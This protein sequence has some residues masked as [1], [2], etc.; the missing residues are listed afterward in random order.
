M[1]R[2]I[3]FLFSIA[4][5]ASAYSAS[6]TTE[7]IDELFAV[8]KTEKTLDAAYGNMDKFMRQMLNDSLRGEKLTPGQQKYIDDFSAKYVQGIREELSWSKLHPLFVQIYQDT[9]SQEEI[10]GLVA[11]YKSPAG[12]A[13]VEKM[14]L[15]M[16]KSMVAMQG[17]LVPLME[18]MK[19]AARQA[20]A[21]AK[22]AK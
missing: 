15:V 6:P 17:R 22:A 4:V 21:D 12:A 11:F 16:Q 7:S 2:I 9:F 10:D 1:S 18:K 3:F 5:S 14:P 13:F 8:T 19:A 20:A